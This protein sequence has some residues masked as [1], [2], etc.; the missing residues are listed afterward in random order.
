MSPETNHRIVCLSQ[1]LTCEAVA[2]KLQR[3]LYSVTVGELGS[4][5]ESMEKNLR[6]LLEVSARWNAITLLDEA[7][8]FMQKRQDADI[9]RNGFVGIF[10]RLLEYHRGI[11]FLTTN[12]VESFDDA[13]KS[14]ISLHL[15]YHPLDEAARLQVWNTFLARGAPSTVDVEKFSKFRLNGREIRSILRLASALRSAEGG[16]S[17]K[18][19]HVEQILAI[20]GGR[21]ERD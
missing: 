15:T 20:Q 13:F 1:T 2:E 3:P 18:D 14:R 12:R 19:S 16:E 8:I 5:L 6:D 4:N 10:L 9:E 7:D 11:L 17:L 21:F